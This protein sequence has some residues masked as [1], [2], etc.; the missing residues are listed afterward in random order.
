MTV[1]NVLQVEVQVFISSI[2]FTCFVLF[3]FVLFCFVLFCFVLFCFVLF[4][5]VLFCFVLFCFVHTS[6]FIN[7]FVGAS[8][9]RE[10][11]SRVS[12]ANE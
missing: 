2:F 11:L 7:L 6:L 9:Q 10:C 1:F 12:K 4:C 8:V 5:F 3:C